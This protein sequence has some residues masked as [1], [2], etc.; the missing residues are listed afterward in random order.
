MKDEEPL[1]SLEILK[2]ALQ[3]IDGPDFYDCGS[4]FKKDLKWVVVNALK[5]V[6][7]TFWYKWECC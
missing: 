7:V 6:I 4:E 1:T 2:E 5:Y 3:A